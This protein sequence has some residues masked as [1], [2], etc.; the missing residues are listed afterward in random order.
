MATKLKR[1]NWVPVYRVSNYCEIGHNDWKEFKIERSAGS[2]VKMWWV[3]DAVRMICL[4]RSE[5]D[6]SD[7]RLVWLERK[8]M[9]TEWRVWW[10][11]VWTWLYSV[12]TVRN[13]SLKMESDA[14]V[15]ST[16][17]S[18]AVSQNFI[19]ESLFATS[20]T[21][22]W[23]GWSMAFPKVLRRSALRVRFFKPILITPRA[24]ARGEVIVCRRCRRHAN[25]QISRYRHLS[26]L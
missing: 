10:D 4:A 22:R 17:C 1:K 13:I 25:R 3:S 21:W 16:P 6:D 5:G 24:C 11:N 8:C 26:A 9:V 12:K 20:S 19:H 2:R 18:R 7:F 23:K 15:P 14:R